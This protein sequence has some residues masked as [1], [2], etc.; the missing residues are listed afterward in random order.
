MSQHYL[1][2]GSGPVLRAA[3]DNLN[4]ERP[5]V[6]LS[7]NEDFILEMQNRGFRAVFGDVSQEDTLNRAG[8]KRA[9]AI[10]IAVEDRGQSVLTTLSCRAL[11]RHLLITATASSDDMIPRLRRAGADRVV[12]PFRI[13]AQFVLLATTRPIVSDFLQYVLYNYEAGVETT[14]L[15]MQDNSPWVDKTIGELDLGN[16]YRAFVI[17]VR[18]PNGRF[19]YAP[20]K[21][22]RIALDQVLIVITP[23]HHADEIRLIAHGGE[24]HRPRTLRY[25]SA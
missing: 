15:Y 22:F 18:Q 23:M 5:F 16:R 7:D 17:G 12:S 1:L 10:M 11:N 13:A 6:V 8:I 21:S 19:V 20:H 25:P 9:L 3:L 24:S 4:P 14:E 2:C